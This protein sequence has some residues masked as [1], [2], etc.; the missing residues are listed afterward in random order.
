MEASKIVN[1]FIGNIAGV[2]DQVHSDCW[3]A[4]MGNMSWS[5]RREKM[6]RASEKGRLRTCSQERVDRAVGSG[7][8]DSGSGS[9]GCHM[10]RA[11]HIALLK[12][13]VRVWN[14]WR[15]ESPVEPD[16]RGANLIRANLTKTNLTRAN[17]SGTLLTRANLSGALLTRANLTG[18]DLTEANLTKA[19]LSGA[20][21]SRALLSGANLTGAD[22]HW[23]ELIKANLTRA[24]L[25]SAILSGA[26][27][28]KATL[29]WAELSGANL[30][31]ANLTG[32]N[33]YGALLTEANLSAAL[34]SGAKMTGAD[35]TRADLSGVSLIWANLT[36]ANLS[37]VVLHWANL[38]EALLTAANLTGGRLNRTVL[39][40]IDLSHVRGLDS[41]RHEGPS[42]IDHRT[43]QRSG[44]LPLAFLRGV[45]LSDNLIDYLLSSLL[46]Q[47]IQFFSCFISYSS[48]DQ[49]FADRLHA[50]LQNKGV[51]CWFA[52]HDMQIGAK[53]IDAIDEAIRLR[54]KVLLILSENSVASDWVEG[55]VTRTLDKEREGKQVVLLPVRI[56]D[57]VLET[58]KP[59]ARLLRGQRNIGNF[60]CWKDHDA[61]QKVLE[62]LLRDLKVTQAG[63]S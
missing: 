5:K 27:L 36:R 44:P 28:T 55:E 1:G 32:A 40:N 47:A 25:N 50:D 16:L 63:T 43:L 17:L 52:P 49:K 19:N 57:T 60:T 23:A 31:R 41:C 30:I 29:N 24:E 59:W 56:D 8:D 34:L 4:R 45:G 26:N 7:E 13:G 42:L 9:Q 58:T 39:G 62:K 14:E 48:K 22:L 35:L 54:D 61:Y 37:H 53:I 2:S 12:L 11:E 38:S 33:L 15:E 6:C 10:A 3:C 21:L 20:F 46:N 18:V 51:R